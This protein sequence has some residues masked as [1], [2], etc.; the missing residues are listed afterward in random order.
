MG[1]TSSE[2][3]LPGAE[4]QISEMEKARSV[5]HVENCRLQKIVQFF[6]EIWIIPLSKKMQKIYIYFS[7]SLLFK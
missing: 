7:S 4:K 3:N 2:R 5:L 1:S 6:V